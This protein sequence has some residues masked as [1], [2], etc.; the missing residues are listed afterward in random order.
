MTVVSTKLQYVSQTLATP[1]KR[2]YAAR[3]V[4]HVNDPLDGPLTVQG[5][6]PAI[7]SALTGATVAG[8]DSDTYATVIGYSNISPV[9]YPAERLV[10]TATVNYSTQT[11][12][13]C[14]QLLGQDPINLPPVIRIA[15]LRE[16]EPLLKDQFGDEVVNAAGDPFDDVFKDVTRLR[17]TI[18]INQPTLS[19]NVLNSHLDTVNL[20]TFFELPTASWKFAEPMVEQ[21]YQQNCS[22]YFNVTY[23]FLSAVTWDFELANLGLRVRSGAGVDKVEWPKDDTTNQR[24]I[25][26]APVALL[27][28]GT[29]AAPSDAIIYY[30]GSEPA[31]LPQSGPWE[32]YERRDFGLFGIPTNF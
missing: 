5:G 27:A 6:L 7:G 18:Q 32:G 3:W 13:Q 17:L 29:Q 24:A 14:L 21:R 8:N 15:G 12:E 4:V 10:W 22:P 26:S 20:G 1:Q 25:P 23:Q 11:P 31:L 16:Q 30:D 9:G 19:V 28:D 2:T